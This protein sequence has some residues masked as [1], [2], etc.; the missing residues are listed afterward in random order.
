[1]RKNLGERSSFRSTVFL[2]GEKMAFPAVYLTILSKHDI[3]TGSEVQ[4]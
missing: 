2:R 4:A 3:V 1:M